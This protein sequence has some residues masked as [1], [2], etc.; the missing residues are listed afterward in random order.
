MNN[1]TFNVIEV[2]NEKTFYKTCS[3]NKTLTL[4]EILKHLY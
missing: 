4:N 1:I 3:K 2:T